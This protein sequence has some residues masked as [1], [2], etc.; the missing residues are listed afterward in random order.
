MSSAADTG[1]NTGRGEALHW[2]LLAVNLAIAAYGWA[3]LPDTVPVHWNAAGE[4]DRMGGKLELLALPAGSLG[5]YV[6]LRL[7]PRLDP[8]RANYAQF[9]GTYAVMRL[10][11]L[12][13][14]TA[15]AGVTVLAAGGA[16]VDVGRWIGVIT[17][18]LVAAT[19]NLMGKVRPNFFV[20]IRTP[21][22]LTSK[23]AWVK[24]HRIGGWVMTGFGIALVLASLAGLGQLTGVLGAA[25]AAS[26]LGLA[27][28]SFLV[29]RSD[30]E[31]VTPA[32]T[33]T[34]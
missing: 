29:W 34:A 19:G 23:R 12:V 31:R 22:T 6:L 32:G 5:V 9:A 3:T 10:V 28:Y 1:A 11:V 4:V 7:L 18:L 25:G 26:V 30:P 21:W 16:P 27:V 17:G 33:Q 24:T 8:G 14:L 2:L 20:G 15:L 13:G